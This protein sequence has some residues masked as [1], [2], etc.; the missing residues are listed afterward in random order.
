MLYKILSAGFVV[1][2]SSCFKMFLSLTTS[3]IFAFSD[4]YLTHSLP[5]YSPICAEYI[6]DS[7]KHHIYTYLVG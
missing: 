2:T 7:Q 1:L 6:S 3:I 4:V 5:G